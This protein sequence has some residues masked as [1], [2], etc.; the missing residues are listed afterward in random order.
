MTLAFMMAQ[1]SFQQSSNE[2]NHTWMHGSPFGRLLHLHMLLLPHSDL[3]LFVGQQS[4][5]I[6]ERYAKETKEEDQEGTP[7]EQELEEGG[8]IG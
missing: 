7:S 2:S 1:A 6:D 5:G 3:L 8:G 4:I